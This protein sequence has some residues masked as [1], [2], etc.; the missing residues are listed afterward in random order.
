MHKIKTKTDDFIEAQIN[1][2]VPC[3]WMRVIV[4]ENMEGVK[5]QKS[6]RR[7]VVG[8]IRSWLRNGTVYSVVS[9]LLPKCMDACVYAYVCMHLCMH[10]HYAYMYV[11]MYVYMCACT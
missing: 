11:R 8:G 4:R 9:Q 1:R 2:Q 3:G 5:A 10:V 6:R 7:E